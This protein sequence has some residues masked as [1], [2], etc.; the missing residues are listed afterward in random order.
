MWGTWSL[1]GLPSSLF[2]SLHGH[3]WLLCMF[4]I[5]NFLHFR[6]LETMQS[7][8]Y[9]SK[10]RKHWKVNHWFQAFYLLNTECLCVYQRYTS[11]HYSLVIFTIVVKYPQAELFEVMECFNTVSKDIFRNLVLHEYKR[12]AMSPVLRTDRWNSLV[13]PASW[14]G[15]CAVSVYWLPGVMAETWQHWGTSPVRWTYWNHSTAL[16]CS[17]EDK[18]R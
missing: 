2:H 16:P 12:W 7:T 14:F 4:V 9:D 11:L 13:C 18:H 17:R 6:F 1:N 5:T 15:A 3:R 10:Q 8:K